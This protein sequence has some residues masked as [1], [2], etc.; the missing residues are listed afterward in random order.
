MPP[1]AFPLRFRVSA[2]RISTTPPAVASSTNRIQRLPRFRRERI[3]SNENQERNFA[4]NVVLSGKTI[5]IAADEVT[6]DGDRIPLTNFQ[7]WSVDVDGDES[8]R[9]AKFEALLE[10]RHLT[11]GEKGGIMMQV[12]DVLRLLRGK[13]TVEEACKTLTG[14]QE[15]IQIRDGGEIRRQAAAVEAN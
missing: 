11:D 15:N 14:M 8:E 12:N 9:L 13:P 1:S 7:K 3:V 4:M 10:N 5:A 6:A 2:S